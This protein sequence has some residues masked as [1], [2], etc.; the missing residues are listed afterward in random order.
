MTLPKKDKNMTSLRERFFK[1]RGLG[2]N[3]LAEGFGDD[4]DVA[5][6][7]DPT[8]MSPEQGSKIDKVVQAINQAHTKNVLVAIYLDGSEWGSW[9]DTHEL[10]SVLPKMK[11]EISKLGMSSQKSKVLIK[12]DSQSGYS[13]PEESMKFSISIPMLAE[14]LSKID[15]TIVPKKSIDILA[16]EISGHIDWGAGFANFGQFAAEYSRDT[17]FKDTFFKDKIREV[18]GDLLKFSDETELFFNILYKM[19]NNKKG[20]GK[21]PKKQ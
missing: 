20:I 5:Q 3:P 15:T 16:D 18:G 6:D 12:I 2:V 13:S 14:V 9:H 21:L 8:F 4:G 11:R 7:F 17:Y 1:N 10:A 19:W